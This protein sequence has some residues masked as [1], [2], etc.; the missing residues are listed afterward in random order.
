MMKGFSITQKI[1][2]FA[3]AAFFA[4]SCYQSGFMTMVTGAILG[5]AIAWFFVARYNHR[6]T[7]SAAEINAEKEDKIR[8]KAEVKKAKLHEKAE[9]EKEKAK[10]ASYKQQQKHAK[11]APLTCPRCGSSNVAPLGANKKFSWGKSLGGTLL[12]GNVGALAGY[13]GKNTGETIFVCMDCGK[14]FKAK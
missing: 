5:A 11:V 2:I 12:A 14:Q 13:T 8:S 1:I 4:A 6:K 3:V 10:I 7:M 9:I